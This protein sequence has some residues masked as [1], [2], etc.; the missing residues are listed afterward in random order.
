MA[1]TNVV[2]VDHEI[3]VLG[4]SPV[5]GGKIE[6]EAIIKFAGKFRS[7]QSEPCI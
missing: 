1:A 7:A 3:L 2:F 5:A 6:V 4:A